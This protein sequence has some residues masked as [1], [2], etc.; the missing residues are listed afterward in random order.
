MDTMKKASRS[1]FRYRL[2]DMVVFLKNEILSGAYQPGEYLPSEKVLVE[3]FDLSNKSVRQ[4]LDMLVSEG[5][6]VK[7]NRVGSM[8][9]EQAGKRALVTITLGC[10]PSIERDI[11]LSQLLD[12]FHGQYP[13]IQVK[14]ITVKSV[15]VT[16]TDYMSPVKEFLENNMIDVFTQ[17]SIHF[18]ELAE[19]GLTHMLE[20]IEPEEGIY[21]FLQDWFCKE[22]VCYAKPIIFTPIVLAYN[23]SHFMEEGVPEPDGG[24]TWDDAIRHAAKLSKP[25]ER[26]GLYFYLMSEHRWPAFLL[27]GAT[28][29]DG[30]KGYTG[31]VESGMLDSIRLCKSII[32]NRDIFPHY[33]SE[34]SYD[35]DELFLQGKVSMILTNY[36]TM[37]DLKYS[38]LDYDISPMPHMGEL[39]SLIS[40]I[41]VSINKNS[42][43]K[44]AAKLLVD[45]L[46]SPRAQNM[47]R[48][49]TLSI[50]SIKA[51]AESRLEVPDSI[52]RPS[53]YFL[54]REIPAS[55]R[56]HTALGMS[57]RTFNAFRQI[58]KKYWSDIID[59][60]AMVHLVDEL[61][62]SGLQSE[63]ED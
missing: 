57:I 42:E 43:Q 36:M 38:S 35:V 29:L 28:V 12:D 54:F 5:L 24:W 59:E 15:T 25:G 10:S 26:F 55:F 39:R 11:I 30:G 63:M 60:G 8:V 22:G 44:E 4:G 2:K 41:G 16:S 3:Q 1:T 37:N 51:V 9:T 34:G 50:P 40:S 7:V 31:L 18:Q 56:S 13:E 52:N 23:R 27:Q 58:L 53:R 48:N 47:I 17:N 6:I 61:L 19:K 45:Y 21:P 14:T 46:A 33:L 32:R 62:S 49:Q 20:P